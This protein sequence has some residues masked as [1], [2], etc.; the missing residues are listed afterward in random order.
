MESSLTNFRHQN[1]DTGTVVIEIRKQA[2]SIRMN[3]GDVRKVKKLA[4]RL[5]VRDSDVIRFAVKSMLARL[6]PLYDPEVRGRNLV[7]VFVESGG[8]L[9]RFFEL[10]AMRLESMI[11]EGVEP[12]RRVDRDDIELLALTGGQTPYAALK[13]SE[14][15]RGERDGSDASQLASS[16]RQYLYDKYVFRSGADVRV[17]D[18]PVRLSAAAAGGHHE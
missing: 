18:E 9:L 1:D 7:P 15:H 16:L 8:E 10:D 12:A 3:G 17:V 11:N 14:L 4:Q 2:V 6:A 13:L 5:G